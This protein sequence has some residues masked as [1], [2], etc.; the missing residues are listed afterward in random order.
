MDSNTFPTKGNLIKARNSLALAKLGYDLMDRKRNVLIREIMVLVDQAREIQAE[1]DSTFRDGYQAL[2]KADI[3][4]GISLVQAMSRS[5]PLDDSI[6]IKV[7]S[8]MGV[9]I[10]KVDADS[11]PVNPTYAFYS[12]RESLDAARVAFSRIKDLTI[13]LSAIEN[14]AYRLALSIRKTQKRANALKNITI[15]YYTALSKTI[16]DALEEKERE[17]FSRLKVIK[18]RKTG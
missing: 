11:G 6:Q 8:I 14:S 7:R 18:K 13:Q 4:N 15:P 3:E 10:P 5:V 9:E 12:T 1:I 17:E 2:Q 16:S